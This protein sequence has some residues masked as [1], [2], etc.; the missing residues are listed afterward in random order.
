MISELIYQL[1]KKVFRQSDKDKLLKLF[2][3]SIVCPMSRLKPYWG[4][5]LL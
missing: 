3:L 2:F 5:L 4:K 1:I